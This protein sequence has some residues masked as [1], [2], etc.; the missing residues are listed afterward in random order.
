[1]QPFCMLGHIAK[2]DVENSLK[3]N[4]GRDGKYDGELFR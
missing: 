1:M 2:I 4:I 3:F